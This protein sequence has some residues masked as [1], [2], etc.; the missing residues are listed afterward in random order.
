MSKVT[1]SKK[2]NAMLNTSGGGGG[3]DISGDEWDVW[4]DY[5]YSCIG[6]K[7]QGKDGKFKKTKQLAGYINF[8]MEAGYLPQQDSFY[9]TKCALPAEGE[10][11]S[12]E[13]LEYMEKYTT[14][15]FEWVVDYSVQPNKKVRKQRSPRNPSEEIVIC[16]DF[17]K[18]M[19]DYSKHPASKSDK[20]DLK[21]LRISL[22]GMF[23]NSFARSINLDVK[24]KVMSDKS[25]LYKTA[26]ACGV[27]EDFISSEYDIGV[28]AQG[29]CKWT[30]EY[31]KNVDGGNTYHKMSIK[32]PVAIE[33]LELDD[34]TTISVASQTPSCDVEFTGIT[35]MDGDYSEENLNQVRSEFIRVME[36]GVAFK[37]SP[38]KH[39]DFVLGID[40]KDTDLAKAWEARKEKY[41][42]ENKPKNTPASSK[43]EIDPMVSD[44]VEDVKGE[45]EKS[46]SEK[47]DLDA[48]EL[49]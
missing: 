22:N 20:E 6:A 14:S 17:P 12:P 15:Y 41:K 13:E 1:F 37:P 19:V 25:I 45:E 3:S 23:K 28:L 16:V 32:N 27:L 49:F 40:W 26:N 31:S 43:D 48:N 30:I 42:E 24:N 11:N 7:E 39:P 4:N 34:G 36:K 10:E 47:D 46:V 2:P 44:L 35:L 8:I 18:I 29:V 21:P 38:V 33:E 9:D 5:L